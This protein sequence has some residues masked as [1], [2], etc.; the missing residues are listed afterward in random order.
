[1][2][3]NRLLGAAL[4]ISL[5]IGPFGRAEADDDSGAV[6]DAAGGDDRE[7]PRRRWDY[8]RFSDGPRRVPTPRGASLERARALGLGTRRAASRLLAAPPHPRWVSAARGTVTDELEWPVE[9]GRFGRGF[10]FTRRE[11]RNLRHEG[12][13]IVA[14]EGA[15]VRAVADGIVAY[16]D[17]GIRGFGNCVIL[18]HPNGLVSLYAHNARNTVQAGWRVVAGERIG[19]VG[20]TGISRGPHLHFELRRRGRPIDPA[21][22]LE[23]PARHATAASP[24]PAAAPEAATAAEAGTEAHLA[25]ARTVL[26]GDIDGALLERTGRRF[27]S[28][29][30]PVK[31]GGVARAYEPR[32]HRGIDI[33]AEKGTPVR[34]AAD[35]LVVYVGDA[36]AGLGRSIVLLHRSGQVTVYGSNQNVAVEAGRTVRRGEWIAEV[37]DSGASEGPHLH[38]E[39]HESGALRDPSPLLVHV[40]GS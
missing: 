7:T 30:W 18:V 22:M 34:A 19:F 25:L 11:R 20:S 37:G 32:R 4:V 17:N 33:A 23:R 13:D 29:L 39:L 12:I 35:G 14:P 24:E 26:A 8:S 28:L 36:L 10:G 9:G 27:S 21:T 15:V 38:F 16:S 31:G 6:G 5:L 2:R 3:D 1:M 40:P